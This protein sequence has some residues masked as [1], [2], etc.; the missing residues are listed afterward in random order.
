MDY[1]GL[2]KMTDE[3]LQLELERLEY[4]LRDCH[5]KEEMVMRLQKKTSG[6]PCVHERLA[7]DREKL[8]NYRY[9]VYNG[10]GQIKRCLYI[11]RH[12]SGRKGGEG[13]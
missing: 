2:D 9:E 4:E 7:K 3:Q 13:K 1:V 8:H 11:R 5:E 10:I 12:C 6:E